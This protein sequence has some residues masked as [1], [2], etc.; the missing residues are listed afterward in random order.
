MLNG[1]TDREKFTEGLSFIARTS[2]QKVK[3]TKFIEDYQRF[4]PMLPESGFVA[5]YSDDDVRTHTPLF[6]K[7]GYALSKVEEDDSF[8]LWRLSKKN[9]PIQQ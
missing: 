8:S 4:I 3:L 9:A 7:H 1:R 2:E 6:N 5:F